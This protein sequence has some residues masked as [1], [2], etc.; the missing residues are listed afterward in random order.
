MNL[1]NKDKRKKQEHFD[2]C[3]LFL[4]LLIHLV[5]FFFLFYF[6]TGQKTKKVGL[7]ILKFFLR[8]F[9]LCWQ[10][11]L[12]RISGW[13]SDNSTEIWTPPP[14]LPKKG[15]THGSSFSQPHFFGW[16]GVRRLVSTALL[17]EGE[18]REG[19]VN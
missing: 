10:W 14:P 11:D 16:M 2:K 8:F 18:G 1:V 7:A 3:Y 17:R 5:K 13:I 9:V 19:K 4:F 6:S 15:R 12:G